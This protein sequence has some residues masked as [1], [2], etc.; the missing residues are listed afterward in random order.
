M[1][2][3][4]KSQE[5]K[6]KLDEELRFRA[7]ARRNK[8]LGMWAAERMGMSGGEAKAYAKE[9]VIIDLKEPGVG[10][11]ISKVLKDFKKRGV[12]FTAQDIQAELD[13]LYPIAFKQIST[14]YPEALGKDH[15]R[16]GD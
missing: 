4:E 3:R 11:V 16:V 8:L 1:R 5:A 10:D 14:E 12:K 13:R 9:V 2:E 6:Y 7:E 15:E